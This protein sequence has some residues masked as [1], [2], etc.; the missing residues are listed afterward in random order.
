M[1]I[2]EKFDFV[3]LCFRVGWKFGR[4]TVYTDPLGMVWNDALDGVAQIE[5]KNEP[6]D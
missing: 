5:S 2:S 3:T 4:P 1:K 6:I